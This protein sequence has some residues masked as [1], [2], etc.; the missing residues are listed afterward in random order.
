MTYSQLVN[1]S[2]PAFPLSEEDFPLRN[3]PT[4]IDRDRLTFGV[5][6]EMAIASLPRSTPDPS[7]NDPRDVYSLIPEDHSWTH[8]TQPKIFYTLDHIATKLTEAGIPSAPENRFLPPP[9]NCWIIDRDTSIIRPDCIDARGEIQSAT[10]WHPGRPYNFHEIEV[11]SPPFFYSK[12]ALNT[13]RKTLHLLKSTF[14]VNINPSCGLHVH[15]GNRSQGLSFVTTRNLLATILTFESQI[16]GIHG[17]YRLSGNVYTRGLR[18][19]SELRAI[20]ADGEDIGFTELE[21]LFNNCT[22]MGDLA[23][24]TKLQGDDRGGRRMGY[25]IVNLTDEYR[26]GDGKRTIEF[27]QHEG[28]VNSKV[29][30]NWGRFCVGL[31]EFADTV[32]ETVLKEFLLRHISDTPETFCIGQVCTALGMPDIAEYYT[33]RVAKQRAKDEDTSRRGSLE[34]KKLAIV[35]ETQRNVAELEAQYNR[36]C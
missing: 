31:V 23:D 8:P 3:A 18:S 33:L 22:N 2:F 25:N 34:K 32:D 24:A 9:T 10:P 30:R 19:H 21:Y 5:E 20:V 6:L 35:N 11:I 17:S 1:S 7:P 4:D 26:C 12:G 15:V 16:D 13:V 28:S 27:R 29:V 36:R 14:R